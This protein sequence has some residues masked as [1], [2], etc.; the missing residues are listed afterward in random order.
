MHGAAAADAQK[1]VGV[2]E[3]SL[4]CPP[5]GLRADQ[6]LDRETTFRF[7][8]RRPRAEVL[9]WQRPR[10][11]A[12]AELKR[13]P[14]PGGKPC[15]LCSRFSRELMMRGLAMRQPAPSRPLASHVGKLLAEKV[16]SELGPKV[17]H[18]IGGA[19]ERV[20]PE[21]EAAVGIDM[22]FRTS[23]GQQGA[24]LRFGHG[25]PFGRT[26]PQVVKF[27]RPP[28]GMR[29]LRRDEDVVTILFDLGPAR[30]PQS[31]QED[32]RPAQKPP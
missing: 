14:V 22:A 24:G 3:R 13:L 4:R 30:R 26:N 25:E 20:K 6:V 1:H 2:S 7:R 5:S 18:L 32:E 10:Q 23:P 11:T 19:T 27:A 8:S 9:G 31:G 29:R 28:A 15:T 21:T 12:Y 16:R 17:V